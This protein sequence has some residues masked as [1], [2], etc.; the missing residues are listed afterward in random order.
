M[1]KLILTLASLACMT[2]FAQNQSPTYAMQFT[3]LHGLSQASVSKNLG[4][5][6]KMS[7]DT[8][9]ECEEDRQKFAETWAAINSFNTDGAQDAIRRGE[10]DAAKALEAYSLE[11]K[12][13][14]QI[15]KEARC[16]KISAS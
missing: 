6:E 1:K 12:V 4:W 2:A 10:L 15:F 5:W 11:T 8:V 3:D 7:Y 16:S 13:Y 14:A 9:Q